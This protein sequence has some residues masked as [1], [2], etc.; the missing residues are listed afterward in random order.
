M[1]NVDSLEEEKFKKTVCGIRSTSNYSASIDCIKKQLNLPYSLDDHKIESLL[2]HATRE[3]FGE[4]LD[5]DMVFMALGLLKGFDSPRNHLEDRNGVELVT[6]RRKMFIEMSSYVAD[7]HNHNNKHRKRHYESYDELEA[8]GENAIDAV[9]SALGS[10]DAER[11]KKIAQKI[12]RKR[13]SIIEYLREANKYLIYDEKDNILDVKLQELKNKRKKITVDTQ[14]QSLTSAEGIQDSDETG[15]PEPPDPPEPTPP[16]A[17]S[18]EKARTI[19]FKFCIFLIALVIISGVIDFIF[20][21]L[22]ISSALKSAG[23]E[24]ALV[25]IRFDNPFEYLSFGDDLNLTVIPT[26][27][28]ATLKGLRCKSSAPDIVKIKSESALHIEAAEASKNSKPCDVNIEAYM[29][30]DNNIK[31]E[32]VIH[33]IKNGENDPRG[34]GRQE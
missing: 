6:V 10:E 11:I 29:D 23:Q 17:D 25:S 5:A 2:I 32:M 15:K 4:S 13:R 26:P 8:A 22:A 18:S 12:Y 33:V 34:E 16:P 7:R 24:P 1:E 3:Q 19:A 30:Y 14:N 27:S 20:V 31:D 28:D 9:V 21:Q